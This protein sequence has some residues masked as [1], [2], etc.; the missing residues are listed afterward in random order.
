M[1]RISY[2]TANFHIKNLYKKLGIN[3]RMEVFSRFNTGV[4]LSCAVE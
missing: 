4:K 2:H 3:S 1:L